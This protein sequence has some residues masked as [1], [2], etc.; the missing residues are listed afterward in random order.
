MQNREQELERLLKM[1]EEAL[2]YYADEKNW[3]LHKN[4]ETGAEV[5]RSIQLDDTESFGYQESSESK[6]I[7]KVIAGKHAKAALTEIR[8]WREG[9]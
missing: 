8:E 2:E 4:F 1:A 9:K 3:Y 6:N 5:R 7:L